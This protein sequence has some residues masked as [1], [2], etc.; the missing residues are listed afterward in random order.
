MFLKVCFLLILAHTVFAQATSCE[1]AVSVNV[2]T[3]LATP[4]VYTHDITVSSEYGSSIFCQIDDIQNNNLQDV[5]ILKLTLETLLIMSL[6][7]VAHLLLVVGGKF[8]LPRH[9]IVQFRIVGI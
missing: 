8:L 7:T 2:D 3:D 9:R 1:T 6:S 4:Y 5:R